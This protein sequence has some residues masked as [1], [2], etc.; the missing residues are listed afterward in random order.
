M[1]I[2]AHRPRSLARP[3][4]VLGDKVEV[5]DESKYNFATPIMKSRHM[6]REQVLKGVLKTRRR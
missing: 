6:T 3:L 2:E 1:P 4:E 5:R